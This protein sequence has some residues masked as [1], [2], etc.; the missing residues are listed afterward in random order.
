MYNNEFSFKDISE[1]L[2]CEKYNEITK[3]SFSMVKKMNL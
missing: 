1:L 2:K 3:L